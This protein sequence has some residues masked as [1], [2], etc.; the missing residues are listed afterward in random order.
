MKKDFKCTLC[1]K[2]YSE[3]GLRY[4][5]KVTHKGLKNSF[6]CNKCDKSFSDRF[7]LKRHFEITHTQPGSHICE[8]CT[9]EFKFN[10]LLRQHIS[11]KH[12]KNNALTSKETSIC[13]YCNK[14]VFNIRLKVHI[15]AHVDIENKSYKCSFD[16]CKIVCTTDANL[17]KH[18]KIHQGK[19]RP[20][21]FSCDKCEK[22]YRTHHAL[23]A[24]KKVKHSGEDRKYEC[25]TCGKK[26]TQSGILYIHKKTHIIGHFPCPLCGKVFTTDVRLYKHKV[27][28][29]K[30]EKE[31]CH[32]CQKMVSA[33][34]M[35]EHLKL[36]EEGQKYKCEECDKE[37]I[38]KKQLNQHKKGHLGRSEKSEC[39]ICGDMLSPYALKHHFKIHAG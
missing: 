1:D 19:E 24:H 30:K 26:Y 5:M 31:P 14:S 38:L 9:Q 15:K 32:I 16:G 39:K 22:G 4:H 35:S 36:H 11:N 2:V 6:P 21:S 3:S 7:P 29:S 37:F 34:C 18:E 25:E 28:H 20:K 27:I 17:K 12:S 23:Y 13:E 10:V 8:I 33:Y